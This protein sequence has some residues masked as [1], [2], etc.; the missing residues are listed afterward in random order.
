LSQNAAAPKNLGDILHGK[1]WR[2]A[3]TTAAL[4][5][6]I[7]TKNAKLA[8][9]ATVALLFS[10]ATMIMLHTYG[11]NASFMYSGSQ[12]QHPMTAMW[13]EMGW[14]MA[15]GPIA[16]ILFFGGILTLAVLFVRSL[17]KSD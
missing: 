5:E 11:P 4:L 15:L 14:L 16:M 10:F 3:E 12:G 7:M 2:T 9:A 13:T 8:T 17:A 1:W 6:K